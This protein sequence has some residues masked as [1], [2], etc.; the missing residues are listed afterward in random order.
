MSIPAIP[1]LLYTDTVEKL[2]LTNF[3]S[4]N[5]ALAAESTAAC[6]TRGVAITGVRQLDVMINVV[7]RLS[8]TKI[9]LKVRFSGLASPDPATPTDWGFVMTDNLDAAT[10]ISSA[11]E[12]VIELDLLNVNGVANASV[13][14]RYTTRIQ[15]ISGLHASA[16]VWADNAVAGAVSFV[17]I[18]G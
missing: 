15:Q 1:R 10:G 9:Y 3:V 17:Q 5:D 12:Y 7:D 6:Q 11:Q 18:G 16:I 8:A 14:R 2:V 4:A 13:S